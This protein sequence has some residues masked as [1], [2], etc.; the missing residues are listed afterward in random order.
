MLQEMAGHQ[1]PMVEYR[2]LTSAYPA[3][4]MVVGAHGLVKYTASELLP[5]VSATECGAL[6]LAKRCDQNRI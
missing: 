1:G 6:L 4:L 5:V 2:L 3:C